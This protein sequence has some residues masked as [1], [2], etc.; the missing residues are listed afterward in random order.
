MPILFLDIETTGLDPLTCE[1][2]TLQLMTLS[3]KSIIIK[4]PDTLEFMSTD[5]LQ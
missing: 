4:N 3:G 2:V 5:L 1:L